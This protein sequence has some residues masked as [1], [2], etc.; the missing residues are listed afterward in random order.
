MQVVDV[1]AKRSFPSTDRYCTDYIFTFIFFSVLLIFFI[2][3]FYGYKNGDLSKMG[4]AYDTD[5]INIKFN[6]Y[7]KFFKRINVG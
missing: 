1:K 2:S 3:I 7:N 4:I 5:G 6:E